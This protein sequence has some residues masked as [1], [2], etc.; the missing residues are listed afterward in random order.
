MIEKITHKN[1]LYAYIL[2]SSFKKK[3]IHF[4]TDKNDT[5]QMGYINYETN[6]KILAH[7]HPPKKKIVK[8]F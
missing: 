6:H 7:H 4:F 5:M 1:R 2:R 3:G 8:I